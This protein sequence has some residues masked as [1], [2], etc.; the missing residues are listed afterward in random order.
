MFGALNKTDLKEN[1][2]NRY[3]GRI[4]FR[5]L[6]KG[7]GGMYFS[8]LCKLRSQNNHKIRVVGIHKWLNDIQDQVIRKQNPKTQ[9]IAPE[10]NLIERGIKT[11][12]ATIKT[13]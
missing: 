10:D 13:D 5:S 1:D 9:Q 4:D 2:Q 7:G 12:N 6:P 3:A 11:R 8:N